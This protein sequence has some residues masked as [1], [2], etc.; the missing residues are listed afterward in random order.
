VGVLDDFSKSAS[1]AFKSEGE[2]IIV[3]G[4]TQG[5]L[6]QSMYLRDICGRE[7]GAPPPVDLIEEKENGDFVRGLILEGAVSAAHDLSDGGLLVAIA[8]MALASGLGAR[9]DAAPEDVAAHAYWFGE[10][11]ARY[12]VTVPAAQ[13]EA[14]MA[15]ARDA[16]VLAT[17]IGVVGGDAVAISGERAAP[18]AKLRDGFEGWLPTYMAG[19]VA[20]TA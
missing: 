1:L 19:E 9:L 8:E 18:L 13:A 14:L 16:S 12:L 5:W 15:K 4:E 3:I 2:A 11:Q 10:D 20:P 17:Q 6:G 7:E